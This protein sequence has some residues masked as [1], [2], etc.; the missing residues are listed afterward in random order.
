MTTKD[1]YYQILQVNPHARPEVIKAAYKTLMQIYH[2]DIYKGDN[3]N[4]N[5]AQKINEAKRVLIDDKLKVEY[6]KERNNLK[7]Q[8]IKG[9][10]IQELISDGELGTTYKARNILTD[11]LVCICDSTG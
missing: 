1:D 10:E 3:K 8:T 7:G 5:I 2:P 9:Y 11:K 6:D 4:D